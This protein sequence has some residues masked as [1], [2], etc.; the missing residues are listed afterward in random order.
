[1]LKK[2]IVLLSNDQIKLISFDEQDD[3]EFN[4]KYINTNINNNL[5]KKI[6]GQSK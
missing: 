1:M 2:N 6:K 3:K 5:T 4:N